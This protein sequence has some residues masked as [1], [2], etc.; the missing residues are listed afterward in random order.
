MRF[1]A[2]DSWR[3][4]CAILVVLFHFPIF[5]LVKSQ[6]LIEHAYLFVDFFF[7]L[8]GFVIGRAYERRIQAPGET[9]PF[10]L[11]RLGRLWPLHATI[12]GVLVLIALIRGDLGQ[13]ERH[14]IA[15]I[16]TNLAMVHGFGIHDSL[17]WNDSSWSISVELLL[18]LLFAALSLSPWRTWI[19]LGLIASSLV[20][21]TAWAP[22]GMGSTYDFGLFRG[23]AGFFTGVLLARL[24]VRNFQPR[25]EIPTVFLAL[26]FVWMGKFSILAPAVFGLV[27][28]VFAGARGSV[29]QFMQ[30]RPLEKL[31]EWSYSIYMVHSIFV[32]VI[33]A[34]A[35]P[36]GLGR[37]GAHLTANLI[38]EIGVLVVYLAAVI[39]TSALTYRFVEAP[40]RDYVNSI[41]A[42]RPRQTIS[43]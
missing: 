35:K 14:S 32:A 26:L 21:L 29:A 8:S 31:G 5:G 41:A 11:R 20:V 28:Y 19:Y 30:R 3:G 16:F 36:L 24:P 15:S 18:Y 4:I 38:T 27:V 42:R 33:W 13:D 43:A 12:L 1:T 25:A 9:W 17:T 2:L 39:F 37:H 22:S 23:L 34:M 7:V 40:A 10:I 6:P